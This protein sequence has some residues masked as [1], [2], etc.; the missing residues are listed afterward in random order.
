[1]GHKISEWI[2]MTYGDDE[3]DS[4]Y[5]GWLRAFASV[6]ICAWEENEEGRTVDFYVSVKPTNYWWSVLE[7]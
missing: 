5:R 7:K 2:G 6:Q 3:Q 1:M 4:R